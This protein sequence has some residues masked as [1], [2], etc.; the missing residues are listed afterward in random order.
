MQVS[1]LEELSA[2]LHRLRERLQ[3]TSMPRHEPLPSGNAL[4]QAATECKFMLPSPL[5]IASLADTVDRKIATVAVLL[6]RA[7]T[8]ENLPESAQMAADQEYLMTEADY[9]FGKRE[10]HVQD[11]VYGHR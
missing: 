1:D 7:K 8:H 2:R 3:A 9:A 5:T 6:E 4:V 11:S 10:Q